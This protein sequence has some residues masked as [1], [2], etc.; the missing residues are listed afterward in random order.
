[1]T[2]DT[3]MTPAQYKRALRQLGLSRAA[4]GRLVNVSERTARRYVSGAA[5][6]P[7]ATALLLRLMIS[8][9]IEAP[10]V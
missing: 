1:M 4:A 8:L 6:I 9:K 5:E 7:G 10:K 2:W 3:H